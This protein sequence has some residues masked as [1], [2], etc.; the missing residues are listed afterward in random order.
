M[1]KEVPMEKFTYALTDGHV[2]ELPKFEDIEVGVIRKIRKLGQ[3][4]QIFTLIE[5]YLNEGELERFD[6][7]QR[8]ELE[9]F[10][11]AWQKGSS[12]AP[13]ESSASSS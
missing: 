8:A 9:K 12:V 11:Q 3:V 5:H 7:M 6:Q 1:L 10:A 4:D 2:L 13:G